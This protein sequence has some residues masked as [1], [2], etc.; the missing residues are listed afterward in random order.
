M[1]FHVLGPAH[2]IEEDRVFELSKEF[3]DFKS[4]LLRF[5]DVYIIMDI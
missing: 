1:Q 4:D 2:F 3:S 5:L